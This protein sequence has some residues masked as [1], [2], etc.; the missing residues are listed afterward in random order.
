MRLRSFARGR[1]CIPY[2]GLTLHPWN[3]EPLHLDPRG[4]WPSDFDMAWFAMV[5][6]DRLDLWHVYPNTP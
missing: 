4:H 6:F 1:L 2:G 3:R 5:V